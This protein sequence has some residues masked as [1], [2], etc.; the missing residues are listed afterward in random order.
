MPTR[1]RF[2]RISWNRSTEADQIS[3]YYR[4]LSAPQMT[5]VL[6]I[7]SLA[8]S[9]GLQSVT[10]YCI[11]LHKIDPTYTVFII[12]DHGVMRH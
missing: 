2:S 5:N 10:E 8:L 12:F 4:G 1:R 3:Q 7:T 6:D 9:G 11:K